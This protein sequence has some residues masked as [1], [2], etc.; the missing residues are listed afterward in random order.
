VRDR[1]GGDADEA[2]IGHRH[3]VTVSGGTRHTIVIP[4]AANTPLIGDTG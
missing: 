3:I 1:H 2:R 4:G